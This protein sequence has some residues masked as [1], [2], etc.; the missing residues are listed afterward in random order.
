[1]A[2]QHVTCS[3]VLIHTRP[4]FFLVCE[5]TP[6]CLSSPNLVSQRIPKELT[7]F[8]LHQ[9]PK[10]AVSNASKATR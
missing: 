7:V 1:M 5:S 10:D 4:E 2:T 8:S 3:L 6:P 9:N